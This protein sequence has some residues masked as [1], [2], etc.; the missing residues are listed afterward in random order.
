[1]SFY[2]FFKIRLTSLRH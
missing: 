2:L 1:L